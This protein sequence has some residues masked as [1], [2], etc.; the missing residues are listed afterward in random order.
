MRLK[1]LDED[2]YY[3]LVGFCGGTIP[4]R[5]LSPEA[6]EKLKE[7]LQNDSAHSPNDKEKLNG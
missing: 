6:R 7:Q 3:R 1:F 2:E 4:I 5:Y